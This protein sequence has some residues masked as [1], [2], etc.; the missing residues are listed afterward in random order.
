MSK[1]SSDVRVE[2][3]LEFDDCVDTCEPEVNRSCV[4]WREELRAKCI[5]SVTSQYVEPDD[6]SSEYPRTM[7]KMQWELIQNQK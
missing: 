5:Q 2:E 4:S 3:F 6:K 1:L 7:K